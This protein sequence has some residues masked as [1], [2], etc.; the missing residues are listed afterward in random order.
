MKLLRSKGP[1]Y[2]QIK[3][4]LKERIITGVYPIESLMPSEPEL[5]REFN[6]SKITIRK[7]VEQ[8]ASDGYVEKQSGVGTTVKDN[9]IVSKLSNAQGFTEYL[10]AQGFDLKKEPIQIEKIKVEDHPIIK[11]YFTDEC[12][13]IQ[14]LYLLDGHPF[15]HMSHYVSGAIHLPSEPEAFKASLYSMLYDE[16]VEFTRFKDSYGMAQP[17]EE[18]G[19]WLKKENTPLFRR[20]RYSYDQK[21]S[22]VELAI[23]YYNTDIHEYIV[24]FDV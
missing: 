18:I 13:C 11:D 23:G 24:N 3:N 22:L 16:G 21:D 14:R 2:L 6:V 15:I 9:R 4:V 17:I 7:A 10:L 8:L 1:F 12:Y 20:I 19:R 5:E